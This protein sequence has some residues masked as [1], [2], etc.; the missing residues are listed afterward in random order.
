MARSVSISTPIPT[1]EE[2]GKSLGISKKRQDSLLRVVR[3]DSKS[4]QL[5]ERKRDSVGTFNEN[6]TAFRTKK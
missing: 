4:G 6:R 5:V 3:R 1:L 2:F